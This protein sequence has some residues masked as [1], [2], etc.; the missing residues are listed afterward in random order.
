MFFMTEKK[1]RAIVR[2]EIEAAAIDYGGLHDE[3]RLIAHSVTRA[4]IVSLAGQVVAALPDPAESHA[5]ARAMWAEQREAGGRL[6]L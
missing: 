2:E 4:M 3:A 1:L 5:E 6:D